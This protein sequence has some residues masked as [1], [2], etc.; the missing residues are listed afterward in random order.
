MNF[1]FFVVVHCKQMVCDIRKPNGQ[2]KLAIIFGFIS[3]SIANRMNEKNR[4]HLVEFDWMLSCRQVLLFNCS[5]HSI[6]ILRFLSFFRCFNS[7]RWQETISSLR[8]SML[9]ALCER[10]HAMTEKK[11]SAHK[12]DN[13]KEEEKKANFRCLL[14]STKRR[15]TF[16]WYMISIS[17]YFDRIIEKRVKWKTVLF[18]GFFYIETLYFIYLYIF[19]V[20]VWNLKYAAQSNSTYLMMKEN[21]RSLVSNHSKPNQI[22]YVWKQKKKE[23]KYRN[24][25]NR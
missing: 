8:K 10:W 25:C 23:E 4:S 13:E 9:F 14:W 17:I 3:W 5:A 20:V 7:I 18:F 1:V 6:N 21:I 16:N 15:R 11:F 24:T 22:E 19:F 2:V 12:T